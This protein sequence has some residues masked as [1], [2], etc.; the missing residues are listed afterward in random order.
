MTEARWPNGDD[1]FHVNYA[2]AE[3][4]TG[5]S[6]LID[7]NLPNIDWTGAKVKFRSGIDPYAAQTATVT[8]SAQGRLAIVLDAPDD[9]LYYPESGGSYHLYR[10]LGALDKHGEW[11]YDTH[12]AVLYF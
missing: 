8:A 1:L 7:S 2:T 11:F 12:A 5:D 6:Q 3:T 10:S 4:G 9:S